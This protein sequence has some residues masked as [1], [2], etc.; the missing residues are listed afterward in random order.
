MLLLLS[1][2]N[3]R[4]QPACKEEKPRA[5]LFQGGQ[6]NRGNRHIYLIMLIKKI[7]AQRSHFYQSLQQKMLGM[8]FFRHFGTTVQVIPASRQ[9]LRVRW[10]SR[11]H[12]AQNILIQVIHR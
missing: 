7:Y 9:P 8:G 4:Q 10:L 11:L 5:E 1:L 3:R 6:Y 2:K 12:L